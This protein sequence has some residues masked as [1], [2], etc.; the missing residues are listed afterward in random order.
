[1]KDL[2]KLLLGRAGGVF[3]S[4]LRPFAAGRYFLNH[5]LTNSLNTSIRE[6]QHGGVSLKFSAPN[7]VN[8]F[9]VNTFSTKE[10]ETLQWID[11]IPTGSCLWDIGANVGIY[12]CYAAKQKGCK[13]F[14]FEPSVF[15]LETL[16]RNIWLNGLTEQVTIFPLPLSDS[17][18]VSKMNMS[19]TEWGGAMSSFRETITH[20]G[21]I[22][23]KVFEY[24]ILGLTMDQA[25]ELLD[26]PQPDYIKMDVDGIEHL[27][28]GGGSQVLAKTQGVLVE[29]NE[30]FERQKNDASM[31]LNRAGLVLAEK[32]RSDIFDDTPY[33]SSYNQIWVRNPH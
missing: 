6:V 24:S 15:N 23:S 29:I 12:S 9:R 20:D 1:M 26:I 13:V 25:M 30:V 21:T 11:S 22:L 17:L 16:S 8:E 31:Y 3:V 18:G 28:L 2:I 27:I 19:S 32:R 33:A 14:A 7:A 5:V 10:P 4:A